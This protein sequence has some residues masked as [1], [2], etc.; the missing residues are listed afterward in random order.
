MGGQFQICERK[1]FE[2]SPKI[3]VQNATLC[4]NE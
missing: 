3:G 2:D 4:A 1:I